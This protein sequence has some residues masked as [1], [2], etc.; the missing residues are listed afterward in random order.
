MKKILVI[1]IVSLFVNFFIPSFSSAAIVSVSEL[2]VEDVETS[3]TKVRKFRDI[4]Y[5][6]AR[7]LVI[8]TDYLKSHLTV[9]T[10]TGYTRNN[11]LMISR[12][13]QDMNHQVLA[14]NDQE[15]STLI[16]LENIPE[17]KKY[18]ISYK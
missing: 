1:F 4:S 9:R 3:K 2:S 10:I 11:F 16:E 6:E 13:L 7:K 14:V 15:I 12:V 8:V 17:A 18:V 5:E